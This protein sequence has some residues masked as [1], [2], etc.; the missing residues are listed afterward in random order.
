MVRPLRVGVG[1]LMEYEFR[2]WT[3]IGKLPAEL[4]GSANSLSLSLE[5]GFIVI[6]ATNPLRPFRGFRGGP[7]VSSRVVT[8]VAGGSYIP[9]SVRQHSHY[10]G[11]S[12]PGTVF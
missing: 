4:A 6:I 3:E 2:G 7:D 9:V 11:S 10:A 12:E 1:L 5:I 8:Q